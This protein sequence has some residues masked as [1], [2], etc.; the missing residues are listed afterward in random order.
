MF[1]VLKISCKNMLNEFVFLYLDSKHVID[2]LTS[3]HLKGKLEE[4]FPYVGP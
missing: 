1:L 3:K 4:A 2:Q